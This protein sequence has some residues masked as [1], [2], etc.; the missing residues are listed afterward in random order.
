MLC[1]IYDDGF[2]NTYGD[3]EPLTNI[4]E[5]ETVYAIE[6]LPAS[7]PAQGHTS[8]EFESTCIQ[9]IVTHIERINTPSKW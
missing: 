8:S 3:D 9:I 1:Q 5:F 2:R 6:M 7:S 4:P